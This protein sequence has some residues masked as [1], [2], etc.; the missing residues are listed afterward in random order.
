MR[1]CPAAHPVIRI[2]AGGRPG[3]TMLA[4]ALRAPFALTKEPGRAN[5]LGSPG[6]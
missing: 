2:A 3:A 1:I 4:A 6:M 5:A